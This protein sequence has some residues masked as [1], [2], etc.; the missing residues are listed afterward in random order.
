MDISG[1]KLQVQVAEQE[2]AIRHV[3]ALL[4]GTVHGIL[5]RQDPAE[6]SECRVYS[7][8][9][10]NE[11]LHKMHLHAEIRNADRAKAVQHEEH[12]AL[13]Q[14]LADA[15]AHLWYGPWLLHCCRYSS[16]LAVGATLA[17]AATLFEYDAALA[18]GAAT[19]AVAAAL[20]AADAAA[21]G[22]LKFLQE[23]E[24]FHCHTGKLS[25]R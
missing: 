18:V 2:A 12:H 8:A 6:G 22:G 20:A 10:H 15:K 4:S 9:D 17:V 21:N 3:T 11:M 7:Q 25:G 19:L 5:R 24:G 13:A 16:A 1:T 23:V 14:E